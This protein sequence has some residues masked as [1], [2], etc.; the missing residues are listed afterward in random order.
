MAEVRCEMCERGE[1]WA[2]CCNGSGGCACEG[3]Q[4]YWGVCLVCN[5]TGR[6]ASDADKTANLKA[7]RA[8]AQATGGYLGNPH[9]KLR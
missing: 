8:H 9:G 2:E 3:R 5:G 7:I 1:V 6:C 4:V